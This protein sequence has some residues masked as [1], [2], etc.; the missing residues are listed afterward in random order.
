LVSRKTL[1]ILVLLNTLLVFLI[2]FP[3]AANQDA[4]LEIKAVIIKK[5]GTTMEVVAPVWINGAFDYANRPF[6]FR[7]G[8][9]VTLTAPAELYGAK[10]AFWQK[11]EGPTFQGQIIAQRTITITLDQ[12]K[13]IWWMNFAE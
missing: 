9:T 13:Q 5:D 7:M 12:P 11:E 3:L 4:W 10:F 1:E 6:K 2:I 8:Q